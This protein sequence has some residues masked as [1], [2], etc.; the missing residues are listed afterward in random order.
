MPARYVRTKRYKKT[1]GKACIVG[2][3]TTSAKVV[4]EKIRFGMRTE[5]ALCETHAIE[6]NLIA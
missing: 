1:I 5:V 3:C 6:R 2:A 4:T